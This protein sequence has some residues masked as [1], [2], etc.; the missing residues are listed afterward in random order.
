MRRQQIAG[1]FDSGDGLF[2]GHRRKVIQKP[3]QTVAG[4]EVIDQVLQR[5]TGPRKHGSASQH[6]GLRRHDGFKGRHRLVPIAG[7]MIQ[8]AG[9]G[10]LTPRWEPTAPNEGM[11]SAAQTGRRVM[12]RSSGGRTCEAGGAHHISDLQVGIF[13]ETYQI[14]EINDLRV[15]NGK[16]YAGVIPKAEVYRH[17]FLTAHPSTR[18]KAPTRG[19]FGLQLLAT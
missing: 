6:I 14:N 9:V 2:A 19:C 18:R 7:L 3:L 11:E 17:S 1:D 15:Y 16:M 12:P 10:R 5:H 8:P 13:T 4:G